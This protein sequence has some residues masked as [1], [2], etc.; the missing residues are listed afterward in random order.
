MDGNISS[1]YAQSGWILLTVLA[2]LVLM[3]IMT[4]VIAL[5]R[6]FSLWRAKRDNREALACFSSA[7]SLAEV[8]Y[9][10]INIWLVAYAILW[11]KLCVAMKQG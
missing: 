8:S 11:N 2:I 9:L 3:S 6:C 10:S 4:W 1:I 5:I 7:E